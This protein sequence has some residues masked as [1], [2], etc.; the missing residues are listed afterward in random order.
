MRSPVRFHNDPTTQADDRALVIESLSYA[1]LR[2]TPLLLIMAAML[3]TLL[4][5]RFDSHIGVVSELAKDIV[6]GAMGNM[7]PSPAKLM[8]R[9]SGRPELRYEDVYAPTIPNAENFHPSQTPP[10]II[11]R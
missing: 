8:T 4:S 5:L 7:M 9:R 3:M 10:S 6:I 1:L 11:R 2:L